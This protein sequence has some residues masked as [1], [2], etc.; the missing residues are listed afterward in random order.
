MLS[1]ES[2]GTAQT[3]RQASRHTATARIDAALREAIR[4]LHVDGVPAGAV[5]LVGVSGGQDSLCLAHALWR[6]R[7][8]H[9]WALHVV[10]VDHG[11][12]AEGAAEGAYVAAV[13]GAWGLPVRV[14]R[15]DVR[16]YQRRERL[17]VQEAARYARY[18]AFA[19][20]AEARGAAGVAVAHTA[21]DVA[22]TLLLHLLRGAGLDGLAAMPLA[23]ALPA[24]ALGPADDGGPLPSALRVLRPLLTVARADTAA[25]CAEQRLRPVPAEPVHYRRDRLRHDLLPALQG[26]NPAV[27]RALAGAAAALAEE[28]AALDTWA[29]RLLEQLPRDSE[30][31]VIPLG[32]WRAL[33]T[34]MQ[35]RLLG[36][37]AA[38]LGGPRTR[39]GRR[40]L[41]SAL[42][43]AGG[44]AGRGIDLPSG[45]RL[46]REPAAL[47][48]RRRGAPSSAPAGPWHL[49]VPGAV[50]IPGVGTLRAERCP[51]PP[52]AL[53]D[54]PPT[55][56]WLDAAAVAE[57]LTVRW[58]QPGDRFQPLGMAS[59]KR[60]QDFLVDA[61]V[62]RATR[63]RLPLV[64]AGG[65]IA[66][67]V[68]QR[69][70]EWAR[71]RPETGAVLHLTFEPVR[72][73][74]VTERGEGY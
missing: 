41:A 14:M 68:G 70:A 67:V 33:P 71:V 55:E 15:V 28:R 44:Q 32:E 7:A 39:L 31:V 73:D 11:I 40:Q 69:I 54:T 37:A 4:A 24:A 9:G 26:Y 5:V 48:L 10:H 21:D 22:E 17:N 57:P 49:P 25:Y 63:A 46:E 35:K 51:A 19:R 36:A 45:L 53:A 42:R 6:L 65:R 38:A 52:R 27:R 62:P 29:A 16:G 8:E 23:R 60:L 47:R 3:A 34:A 59:E 58:R 61:R 2:A 12:R 56:C 30:Q 20:E 72:P 13:C 64:V 1:A 66:W 43:L 74:R 18:Q 50:A